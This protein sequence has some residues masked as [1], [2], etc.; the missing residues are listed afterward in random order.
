MA[1]RRGGMGTAAGALRS[2]DADTLRADGR[3]P[4]APAGQRILELAA[5]PGETVSWR[6]HGPAR[7]CAPLDGCGTGDGR[8][9]RRRA[10]GARAHRCR[11]RGRGRGRALVGDG[12]V[13]GILCRFGLDARARD[14]ARRGRDR[15]RPAPWRRAVLAVW[16]SSRLNPWMTATGRAALELGFAEPPDPMRPGRSGW[17]TPTTAGRSSPPEASTIDDRRGGAGHL[18]RRVARRVVGDDPRH[19]A[20]ALPPARTALRGRGRRCGPGRGASAEYVA[21]DGSLVVPGLARVVVV[22]GD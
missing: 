11:V 12:A 21:A 13:D 22:T 5:G 7:W 8:G 1:E 14:G 19:L 9:A 17:P 16:A 10:P 4:R 3:A 2:R 20:A 18:G 15:P 6:W